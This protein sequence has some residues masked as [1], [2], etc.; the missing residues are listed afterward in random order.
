LL[1]C[2]CNP[3]FTSSY[4]RHS[5]LPLPG[6]RRSPPFRRQGRRRTSIVNSSPASTSSSPAAASYSLQTHTFS[7][8]RPAS[9][10]SKIIWRPSSSSSRTSASFAARFHRC[11]T[12]SS[13][14]GQA[15][16]RPAQHH[17]KY[18]TFRV[19]QAPSAARLVRRSNSTK[20]RLY[21]DPVER[22]VHQLRSCVNDDV[23]S[24]SPPMRCTPRP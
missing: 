3:S 2:P 1:V 6:S 18:A 14:L 19:L 9:S 23:R 4:R 21:I 11:S 16:R 12:S 17:L 22:L 7:T 13:R 5:L 24:S 20:P 8:S 15:P 10:A